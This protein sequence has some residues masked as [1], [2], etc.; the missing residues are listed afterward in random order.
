MCL[1]RLSQFG[2]FSRDHGLQCCSIFFKVW[3]CEENLIILLQKFSGIVGKNLT[4]NKL[5]SHLDFPL[6]KNQNLST[7]LETIKKVHFLFPVSS[8]CIS[9]EGWQYGI[10]FETGEF[11]FIENAALVAIMFDSSKIKLILSCETPNRYDT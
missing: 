10:L 3:I 6:N 1:I 9:K 8:C 2:L 5:N 4:R 7:I 11:R